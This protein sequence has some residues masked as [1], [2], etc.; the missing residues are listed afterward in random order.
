MTVRRRRDGLGPGSRLS[1]DII[2]RHPSALPQGTCLLERDA[3]RRQRV[4]S[5]DA[6]GALKPQFDLPAVCCIIGAI[7]PCPVRASDPRPRSA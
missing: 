1:F 5:A 3:S 4:G 2:L 6:P 7:A